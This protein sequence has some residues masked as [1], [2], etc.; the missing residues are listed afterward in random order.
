MC[1][2]KRMQSV[3]AVAAFCA[4]AMIAGGL[5]IAGAPVARGQAASIE[6]VVQVTPAGG[7][8][9]PVRGFTFYLLSKSFFEIQQEVDSS[10]PKPDM[11]AYI[12]GLKVSPEL[13]AWMKKHQVVSLEGEDFLKSLHA[14]DILNVPEFFDAYLDRN[15]CDQTMNFPKPKYKPR[16]KEKDPERYAKLRQEYLDNIRKFFEANPETA[17]GLDISL[18][19]INPGPHWQSELGKRPPAVRRRT[20]ELAQTKYLVGRAET[21]LNGRGEINGV[22]AGDYWLCTLDVF[23]TVGDARLQWD[24]PVSASAG[25]TTRVDLTNSNAHEPI[26]AAQ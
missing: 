10:V 11:N 22:P 2:M 25:R 18:S 14:D 19:T 23:A 17:V 6:F 12:D 20:M 3:R 8:A 7:T 24:V 16:D 1:G 21:D 4:S 26:K 5:A 15:A 9:E 13:K